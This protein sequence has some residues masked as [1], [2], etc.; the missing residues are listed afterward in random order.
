MSLSKF[1]YVKKPSYNSFDLS[2]S[3]CLTGNMGKL[4]PILA[5]EVYPG[6]IFNLKSTVFIRTKPMI[7]A[8]FQNI[9]CTQRYFYVPLRFLMNHDDFEEYISGGKNLETIEQK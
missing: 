2:H 8:P 1:M 7:T 5:T 3:N 4:L 6:D 9:R